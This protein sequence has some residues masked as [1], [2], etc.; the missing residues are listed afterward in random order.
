[1]KI[2]NCAAKVT[3]LQLSRLPFIRVFVRKQ[4]CI[5]R[6]RQMFSVPL[7]SLHKR[8]GEDV[9]DRKAGLGRVLFTSPPFNQ[10]RLV[11]NEPFDG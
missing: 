1:M 10:L 5:K 3:R 11:E 7:G 6:N 9:R 4:R 8:R 2:G